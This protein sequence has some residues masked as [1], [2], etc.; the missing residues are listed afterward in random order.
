MTQPYY[1]GLDV[2]KRQVD[3]ATCPVSAPGALCP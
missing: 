2:A 3:F 1:V